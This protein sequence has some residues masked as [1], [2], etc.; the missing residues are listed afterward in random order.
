MNT[1]IHTCFFPLLSVNELMLCHPWVLNT[2]SSLPT[3]D[4]LFLIM[5]KKANT[6]IIIHKSFEKLL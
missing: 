1:K 3:N 5:E 2:T 4:W 6:K